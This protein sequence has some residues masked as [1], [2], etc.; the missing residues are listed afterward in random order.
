M[1]ST[2]A[3]AVAGEAVRSH[4]PI[5]SVPTAHGTVRVRHRCARPTCTEMRDRAAVADTA[6]ATVRPVPDPERA[7]IVVATRISDT[8]SGQRFGGSA[9]EFVSVPVSYGRFGGLYRR[10]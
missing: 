10:S 6:R 5:I 3:S 8:A 2:V 7:G 1:G 9:A 4:R